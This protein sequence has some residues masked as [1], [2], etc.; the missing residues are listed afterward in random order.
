MVRAFAGMVP[1]GFLFAQEGAGIKLKFC[2]FCDKSHIICWFQAGI[3]LDFIVI[4]N[5][6]IDGVTYTE[7]LIDIHG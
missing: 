3:R 2:S 1:Y 6:I 7:H 4:L 5:R